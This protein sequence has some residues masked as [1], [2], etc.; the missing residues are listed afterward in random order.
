[1]DDRWF[2]VDGISED[3]GV[4]RDTVYARLNKC[5]MQ[6]HKF[7]RLWKFKRAEVDGWVRARD[8]LLLTC[9][10]PPSE[11]LDDLRM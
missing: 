1:M 6:G 3:M 7:G 8:R 11:F 9:V 10:D 4:L 5:E 2:S